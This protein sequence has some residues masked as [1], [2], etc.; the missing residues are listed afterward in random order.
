MTQ[1]F[2]VDGAVLPLLAKGL[3]VRSS[4]CV[5]CSSSLQVSVAKCPYSLRKSLNKVELIDNIYVTIQ[6]GIIQVTGY[7][8]PLGMSVCVVLTSPVTG[9]SVLGLHMVIPG[10]AGEDNFKGYYCYYWVGT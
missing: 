10:Q 5:S 3:S 7:R 6:S 2:Q 4:T 1:D 8:R 9:F